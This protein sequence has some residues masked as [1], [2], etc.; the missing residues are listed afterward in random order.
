MMRKLPAVLFDGLLAGI[1]KCRQQDL[2]IFGVKGDRKSGRVHDIATQHRN[3]TSERWHPTA[4][5]KKR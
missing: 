5:P 4:L 1:E 2:E 3:V